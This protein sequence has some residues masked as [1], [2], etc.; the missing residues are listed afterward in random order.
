MSMTCTAL[1]PLG[2]RGPLPQP[3]TVQKVLTEQPPPHTFSAASFLQALL[4]YLQPNITPEE[5][6]LLGTVCCFPEVAT[7]LKASCPGSVQT[8]CRVY[9]WCIYT[10]KNSLRLLFP[11]ESKPDYRENFTSLWSSKDTFSKDHLNAK[12]QKNEKQGW[13]T[14]SSLRAPHQPLKG[15]FFFLL[16]WAQ[17]Y[18]RCFL[19]ASI[20]A[21]LTGTLVSLRAG[22]FHLISFF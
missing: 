16:C 13:A 1:L 20:D 14:Q 12:P 10:Q 6:Q 2:K 3:L 17:I 19:C 5:Q 15:F 8:I 11:E 18:T 4:C 22:F 9:R 7:K 21:D